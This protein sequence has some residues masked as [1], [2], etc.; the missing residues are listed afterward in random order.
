MTVCQTIQNHVN[1]FNRNSMLFI[2]LQPTVNYLIHKNCISFFDLNIFAFYSYHSN[3]SMFSFDVFNDGFNA[4]E[5]MRWVFFSTG[6]KTL[7]YVTQ[8]RLAFHIQK[9]VF[10]LNVRGGGTIEKWFSRVENYNI[11]IPNFIKGG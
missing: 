3:N 6:Y 11:W 9:T 10:P 8:N 7:S 4:I 2:V 5:K 1:S